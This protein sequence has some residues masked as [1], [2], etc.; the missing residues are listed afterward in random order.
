MSQVSVVV[1]TN[2]L[3][4]ALLFGGKP[5]EVLQIVINRDIRGIISSALL[6]ELLDVLA[7]K[8]LFPK[9]KLFLVERKM[10]KAFALV[11]PAEH[12]VILADYA[13]NRVLEAARAGQCQ[14]IITGDK[15]LLKLGSY[16]T[17]SIM[18]PEQFLAENWED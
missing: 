3:I 4:S 2:I 15:G 12:I 11:Y 5:R 10:T 6:S 1:D 18:T 17:I 7:K 14:Y 16:K 13:D 9:H 8:F